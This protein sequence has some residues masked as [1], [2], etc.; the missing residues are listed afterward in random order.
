M[1]LGGDLV[2]MERKKYIDFHTH[3][4][5][6]DGAGTPELNVQLARLKGLDFVAITDHDKTTGYE[7]A[8]KMGE[9]WGIQVIPGVEI[10]TNI[11][12][13]LGLGV[14]IRKPSFVDFINFSNEQQRKVC[15]ARTE[16]LKN[17]GVPITLDKILRIYPDSR[18]GKM[19]IWYTMTQD[20][21]CRDF[22]LTK[23][24]RPLTKKL[25]EKYLRNAQGKEEVV[26]KNTSITAPEA[27][28]QIHNAGGIAIIAHP[29]KEVKQLSE[30]DELVRQGLDGLEVQP[31]FNGENEM[32][33]KYAQEHNLPLT[34]GS[35]Y[36]GGLFGRQMLEIGGDNI[37][38][39][40]IA[41][42]LAIK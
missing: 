6:S 23:E 11:Y 16:V 42:M 34:Y 29:F 28:K 8:R 10:S 25:Y 3:T 2:N 19:N 12:H 37:L 35:D 33:R 24:Q 26:D 36:H 30:L 4:F 7:A 22:F 27:I 31:G 41:E 14:D 39:E 9:K 32:A 21:E 15:I 38:D 13:I 40:R 20:K 17:K 5:Y 1:L 18:L